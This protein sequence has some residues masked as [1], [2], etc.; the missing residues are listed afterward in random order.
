MIKLRG[1]VQ[2][3]Q[4]SGC[5]VCFLCLLT[6]GILNCIWGCR[7]K[8]YQAAMG[9]WQQEFNEDLEPLGMFCKTQTHVYG[10]MQYVYSQHGG[11]MQRQEIRSSW[12]AIAILPDSVA[13]LKAARHFIESGVKGSLNV[14]RPNKCGCGGNRGGV[15]NVI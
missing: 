6:I 2:S 15:D 14:D 3:K 4:R 1:D 7:N 9:R 13:E 12:L 8:R 11:H 5:C 10:Y